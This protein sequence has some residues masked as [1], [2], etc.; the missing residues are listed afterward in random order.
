MKA[1]F[2]PRFKTCGIG[3]FVPMHFLEGVWKRSSLLFF[4]RANGR[5]QQVELTFE[6]KTYIPDTDAIVVRR[7]GFPRSRKTSDDV[8]RH[9]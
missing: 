8:R 5:E 7:G 2:V 1:A 9:G 3:F 4:L 6:D